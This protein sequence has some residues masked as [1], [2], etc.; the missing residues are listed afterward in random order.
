[1]N[2]FAGI[3]M[4]DGAPAD[5]LHE[6]QIVRVLAAPRK[7]PIRLHRDASALI[8]QRAPSPAGFEHTESRTSFVADARLDNRAELGEA[9]GLSSPALER[10]PDNGLLLRMFER[11][12][13]DGIA[14]CL[15]AFAFASWDAGARRL[16]LGRDCLGNRS[17]FFHRGNG[18][19]A[20]ATSLTALLA[21]PCVPREIDEIILAQFLLVDL[22]EPRR[23]FY[24]G[25]AR[26]PSRTI[27]TVDKAG[28]RATHYWSP[29]FD[30]S[31]SF[32]RE[33]DYVERARELFDQ[34]VA[35]A[36]E[37]T[38]DVA[39]STSGGLDSSAIAATAARLRPAQRIACYTLVAP[40]DFRPDVGRFRY[41]D[42][43]EK[44]DALA[45]MHPGLELH[46]ISPEHPHRDVED[47]TRLFVRTGTPVL[48]P[49]NLADFGH[50]YE[51]VAAAGHTVLLDGS[52][53]N[54]GLTWTGNFSL[55]AL[56]ASGR[57]KT[58]G[59]DLLALAR[60]SN[61]SLARTFAA[62]VVV[63]GAPPFLRRLIDRLRGRDPFDVAR[64]SALNP[65]FIADHDLVRQWRDQGFDPRFSEST[66][67][68]A[69]HRARF[70]FDHN[71]VARDF[72]AMSR[73][74]FGFE[75][76]DPH[77]DRRLLEFA[78]S[79]PEPM[80][81]TAGMQRS[82]ARAVFADR[83]P[84][85]ILN[86]TRRGAQSVAWFR[87]LSA[88]RQDISAEIDRLGNSPT[89][90][91]LIDV[92]RLRR[93]ADEWPADAQAAESRRDEYRLLLSRGVHVGRFIRWV[94]G[95]NA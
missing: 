70:L 32:R 79:V 5:V 4:L 81:R 15:G 74:I 44:L 22:S 7:G 26:V 64:Y 36:I 59:G 60:L 49:A 63:R 71:A 67:D 27:V 38:P 50:L 10:T 29:S 43:R 34:A 61:R 30:A 42:E 48:G 35:A 33:Q 77:A 54:F 75:F 82:F 89:A 73:E 6:Q 13:D 68:A 91:R 76:R 80:F 14:R 65:T 8:A 18:F 53:G 55:L 51:T 85:E 17:L 37:D 40:A 92:G 72:K 12:G 20:F 1:M 45:R 16:T 21:L 23:T 41:L 86:E 9:L 39:I 69:A 3:V 87:H 84:P 19:A 95:G 28:I 52:S 24:R 62:E 46:F 58:F 94:E 78:L 2:P 47:D 11:W 56:A 83:L 88:R 57:W 31:P 93:L 25:I 66:W 90:R